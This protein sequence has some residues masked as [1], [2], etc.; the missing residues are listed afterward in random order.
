V[1][2]RKGNPDDRRTRRILER[3]TGS[4][5]AI[6]DSLRGHEGLAEQLQEIEQLFR[7]HGGERS[8]QEARAVLFSWGH[9]QALDRI[10]EGSFGE[11][12]RAYDGILDRDVALKLLKPDQSRPFQSQ[13]FLHEARQLAMVRHPNVLAVHGAAIHQSRPGLWSDL[14]DGQTLPDD[15]HLAE[16]LDLEAWLSLI[17][18]LARALRAVHEA[19]LIHGDVKPSNIMQDASGI[20]VLMDFGASRGRKPDRSEAAMVSGTPLYMAPEVVAGDS[21]REASDWYSLG[22]TLYRAATGQPPHRASDFDGL[23]GL[24]DRAAPIDLSALDRAVPAP[25]ARLIRA[26][27]ARSPDDRPDSR[28]LLDAIDSIRSAPHRRFRRMA[29]GAIASVLLLGL[30]LTSIGFYR[31]NEARLAAEREQRNT[32]AVNEFLQRVI[33]SPDSTGQARDVTVEEM[34]NN[35]AE[36]LAP[37]LQGQPIAQAAVHRALAESF[38]VIE[39]PERALEQIDLGLQRLA[40]SGRVAPEIRQPLE[41]EAIFAL[42]IQDRHE[43]SLSSATDF[44]NRYAD[45]LG[46]EHWYVQRARKYQVT[47]L[48]AM[49]RYDEARVILD[50]HFSEVPDPESASTNLGFEILHA[51]SNLRR[52][53]GDYAGSIEAARASLDWL[54]RNPRNRPSNRASALTNLGLA[55][56]FQGRKREA[57]G[58]L[59]ELFELQGRLFG[60]GSEA[61]ISTLVNYSAI[62]YELGEFE[63]A[64]ETQDRVRAMIEATPGV[65]PEYYA[66]TLEM[67]RANLLNAAGRTAEGEQLIRELLVRGEALLG[68]DHLN[69]LMLEYNLA[70][71][72]NQLGRYDESLEWSTGTTARMIATLGENHPFRW[73]SEANQAQ[74]LAGL[75]R[76]DEAI[77]RHLSAIEALAGIV[78]ADH[79]FSLTARRQAIESRLRIDPDSVER[80]ELEALIDAHLEHLGEQNFETIKVRALLDDF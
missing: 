64:L 30:I 6:E 44:V 63:A 61:Q 26:L 2:P 46:G 12:F 33:A 37:R 32:A 22:A 47:N 7:L 43:E 50:A 59:E 8:A 70:E 4:S 16:A 1:S 58:V 51:R 13:L 53:T 10:G 5:D 41:L 19:G 52:E 31:A 49:S 14:I 71:L 39:H 24:H 17:E 65:V 42:E 38:N 67:N 75:G 68:A 56:N 54:D 29:F 9:L 73:L 55:L 11:V 23:K 25:V 62:Q 27:L 21:A 60:A 80:A 45:V 66:L 3:L 15:G 48:M 69:L 79:P 36:E 76:G 20:W 77:D 72:L 35:A 18:A 74:S 78:G 57:L 28:A 34:L 40:D